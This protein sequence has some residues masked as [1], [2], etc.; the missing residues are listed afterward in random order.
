MFA[1]LVS[2][3][4]LLVA[5]SNVS[6]LRVCVLYV[7]YGNKEEVSVLDIRPLDEQF[8]DLPAQAVICSL[9][10]VQALGPDPKLWSD[11]ARSWFVQAIARQTLLVSIV[12]L[13]SMQEHTLVELYAV[14]GSQKLNIGNMMLN[15]G[16][17]VVPTFNQPQNQA[18]ISFPQQ[19]ASEATAAV[20]FYGSNDGE[21]R[22]SSLSPTMSTTEES[23]LKSPT[24]TGSLQGSNSGGSK[25]SRKIA[26]ARRRC[27]S[28][29]SGEGKKDQSNRNTSPVSDKREQARDTTHTESPVL[30]LHG[31]TYRSFPASSVSCEEAA[32]LQVMVS[33]VQNPGRFYVHVIGKELKKFDTLMH[34]LNEYCNH[35]VMSPLVYPKLD[36][37]C[38]VMFRDDCRWCRSVTVGIQSGEVCVNYVDYGNR[39]WVCPSDVYSLPDR[40]LDLP[41]QAV[42]CTLAEL[43]PHELTPPPSS[44]SQNESEQ[45]D[46]WLAYTVAGPEGKQACRRDTPNLSA[47]WQKAA[48]ELFE[49]LTGDFRVLF[50][51]VVPS[52]RAKCKARSPRSRT[53]SAASS[54]GNQRFI[55]CLHDHT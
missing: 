12:K 37:P 28:S 25:G 7:D 38:A 48:S 40:F 34:Q 33:H 43:C 49:K 45:D 9:N 3:K 41:K 8:F 1:F 32:D 5:A 24:D 22:G 10:G 47:T 18:P 44:T 14:W 19:Q 17:A 27:N 21:H 2:N 15:A 26:L 20:Y 31:L 4:S 50:A 39:E 54:P 6:L 55:S 29:S 35:E 13:P 11:T 23:Q 36:Q 30:P 46:E 53:S 51:K 52:K 16:L 42:E